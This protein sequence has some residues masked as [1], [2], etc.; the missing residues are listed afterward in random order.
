MLWK[1][2]L[3][4]FSGKEVTILVDPLYVSYSQSLGATETVTCSGMYLR[5]HLIPG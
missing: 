4:P 5:T 3:F 2:A 1:S